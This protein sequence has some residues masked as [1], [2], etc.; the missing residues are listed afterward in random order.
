MMSGNPCMK[1]AAVALARGSGRISVS[2]AIFLSLFAHAFGQSASFTNQS[3]PLLGNTQIAADFNGD[4]KPDLA[5]SGLNAGSIMLGNGDGTFRAR[6]NFPVG[7][8]TQDVAAGDF[9]G[10]GKTD[11]AVTLNDPQLSLAILIGTGTGSFNA[12]TYLPNNSGFDSPAVLA[13]D[14]NN[15]GKLDLVVLHNIGCFTAPC[16]SARSIT[17]L[18][19]N[20]DGTFQP[21][22]EID[23]NTFP[24][25]MAVGDFNRDGFKDLAV[26]GENTELSVLSGTGNGNFVLKPLLTIVPG[27]DLFSACN[28]V[29][30]ADFNRDGIQDLVL[31]LGNGNGN[32]IR[33]GNGDGT[34][35]VSTRLLDDAVSAP[36]NIAVADYNRDGFLDLAR[37][38]GD[39]TRGLVQIMR[40]NGDGTFQAPVRYDVP[41]INSS[42]GGIQIMAADFNGDSKPDLALVVG[43][44][45]ASTH[46]L[47]NTTGGTV[48]PGA[49][50]VSSVTLNPSTVAGGNSAI[51]TVTLNLR[52]QAATTVQMASSSAAAKVPASVTV[53]AG[54]I[55]ANFSITTTQVTSTTSAQIRTTLNGT[56]RAATLT[57][58]PTSSAADTITISRVEYDRSKTSL[59]VEATSTRSTATLQVFVTST[60]QLIGTLNNNGGGKFS[61][62][63]SWPV[64]PQNITVRSNFGGSKSSA[65]TVK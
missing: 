27:G 64:N 21:A 36:L 62:E 16:R 31:P 3:Y 60:G 30:V 38:M 23:V 43:G 33:L 4:G 5:G 19:G 54:A 11:L 57:I 9:N 58:N 53:A 8:Q 14:L 15:D 1:S 63:F 45:S 29:D 25:A 7:T 41:P 18:L 35:R 12:P 10:D 65:V 24:H 26:G 13:I 40:G 42:V 2:A 34:F 20:G 44:A 48:P 49:P 28:D 39:G 56:S 61:G 37:A 55:S 22:R 52:P 32:A 51:G 46:I 59:R 17:V 6:T 47:I 50:T